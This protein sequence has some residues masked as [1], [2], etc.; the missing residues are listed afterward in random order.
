MKIVLLISV[1]VVLISCKNTTSPAYSGNLN[2]TWVDSGYEEN[3]RIF[4]KTHGLDENK[5]GFTFYGDGKLIERKN[6]GWCGTPPIAYANFEG[7]WDFVTSD[8]LAINVGYWGGKIAYKLKIV[9]I[10][11]SVLKIEYHY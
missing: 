7:N 6:V 8:S 9:S 4:I 11:E 5:Y 2:G 10:D 1:F 3:V